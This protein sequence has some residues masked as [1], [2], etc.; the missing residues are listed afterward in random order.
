MA[1]TPP[2]ARRAPAGAVALLDI[3]L[4]PGAIVPKSLSVVA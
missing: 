3:A 2:N 4:S 1:P